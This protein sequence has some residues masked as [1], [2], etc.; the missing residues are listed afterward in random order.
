MRTAVDT[1]VLSAIWGR[2]SNA[3][4]MSR[5]LAEARPTGS[6]VISGAVFAEALACPNANEAFVRRFLDQTG[7]VVDFEL[8]EEAWTET[9][10]R[11]ARYAD[12]RRRSS[13][14]GAKPETKRV[15]ADFIVGAHA[16]LRADRMITLDRGR[17]RR[18]FPELTLI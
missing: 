8:G 3:H 9:G 12:R 1:N 14:P 17:Y 13:R 7:V 4:E 2:E 11:Y 15:L 5:M 6:V 16:L 18:D 10:R